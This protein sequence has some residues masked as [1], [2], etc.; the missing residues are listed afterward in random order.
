MADLWRFTSFQCHAIVI[1]W[2]WQILRDDGYFVFRLHATF[3]ANYI[4]FFC[5]INM[6]ELHAIRRLIHRQ[7][8]Q[9]FGHQPLLVIYMKLSNALAQGIPIALCRN[10]IPKELH[11]L[12]LDFYPS[13]VVNYHVR[14]G[15]IP[16]L[17]SVL[18][19]RRD[20]QRPQP[21]L[22]KPWPKASVAE[23]R[24]LPPD[25]WKRDLKTFEP[26]QRQQMSRSANTLSMIWKLTN[27]PNR[28]LFLLTS[29][30]NP[31]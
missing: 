27:D 29:F 13:P 5:E 19:L 21:R 24:P 22:L 11:S 8:D 28:E 26:G 3:M 23:A 20:A 12:S 14:F 9:R 18:P 10:R 16:P 6:M 31:N 1:S 7:N 4:S 30:F 2:S 15:V 17:I 25:L